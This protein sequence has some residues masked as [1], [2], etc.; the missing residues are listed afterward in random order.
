MSAWRALRMDDLAGVLAIADLVHQDHPEDAEVLAERIALFPAGCF[1]LDGA[2]GLA[3]Y[4]LSHP[5]HAGEVP[6]LNRTLGVVPG[7]RDCY[8]V[9]DLAL[10]PDAQGHGAGAAV[11]HRML[12][13]TADFRRHALIAVDGTPAF[14]SRFGFRPAEGADLASY[15]EG[16][17][18]M[19]RPGVA[20]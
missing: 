3:G 13:Q 5:W 1:A 17:T 11:I 7:G 14:W 2:A 15:G 9:H 19:V 12:E 8:F 10:H 6:V 20:F 18:Y 4:L 16:V